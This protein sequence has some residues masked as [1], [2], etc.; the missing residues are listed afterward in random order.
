VAEAREVT[1]GMLLAAANALAESVSA[2]R[3][4]EGALYPPI[5]DL[6]AL[7]R[8]IAVAVV[9][10][11]RDSGFGR[12]LPDDAVEAA[13][14]AAIWNPTYDAYLPARRSGPTPGG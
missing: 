8:S 12:F 11:A 3:L 1:D 14:D 7:A 9:R 4:A 2:A 5:A 13:V 10:E 6:P